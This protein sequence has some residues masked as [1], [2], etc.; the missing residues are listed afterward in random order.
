MLANINHR[1]QQ[2][3]VHHHIPDIDATTTSTT[4][5]SVSPPPVQTTQHMSP[6]QLYTGDTS[7]AKG[8]E[9]KSPQPSSFVPENKRNNTEDEEMTDADHTTIASPPLA[10]NES[11]EDQNM[12]NEKDDD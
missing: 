10:N 3:A 5:H 12:E 9:P 11:V 8:E 7:V 4:R 1:E 2:Q 6:M